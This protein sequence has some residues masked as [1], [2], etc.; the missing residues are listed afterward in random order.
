MT[1]EEILKIKPGDIVL[2][3]DN[4]VYVLQIYDNKSRWALLNMDSGGKTDIPFQVDNYS[5]RG[6]VKEANNE[7]KSKIKRKICKEFFEISYIRN[8]IVKF[9]K[10]K[11]L[12]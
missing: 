8:I 6:L 7:D 5:L 9:L 4:P 10:W 2:Y 3:R 1:K 11:K 12:L